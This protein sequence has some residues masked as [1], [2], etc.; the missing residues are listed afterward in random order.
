MGSKADLLFEKWERLPGAT[1]KHWHQLLARI[2][3][4]ICLRGVDER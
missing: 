3:H 4:V 2:H 1:L